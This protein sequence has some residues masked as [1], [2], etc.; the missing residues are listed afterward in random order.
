MKK[1]LLNFICCPICK[2]DAVDSW[3][4]SVTKES[5][6]EVRE[7]TVTCKK[8]RKIFV[9]EE[10]ILDLLVNPS[11]E[12]VNE[13]AGWAKLEKHVKNDDRLMLSLPNGIGEHKAVWQLQSEN[14]NYMW[15]KIDLKGDEKVLDLGAG[16]CWAT[17]FFAK[18]GC[19]T[20]GLDVLKTKYVGLLTSDVYIN[21]EG[22]YFERLIGNMNDIPIKKAVFDIVFMAATLHH[23]SDINRTIQQVYNSLK[24]GG[25]LIMINEPGLSIFG[26]KKLTCPEVENG[27][28]EHVYRLNEYSKVLRHNGFSYDLYPYVGS[29][30][31]IIQKLNGGLTRI[32]PKQL[33]PKR[34][35]KPLLIAQL[36]FW[37]GV[38]HVMARKR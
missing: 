1:Q 33:I 16:R 35:W 15:S 19:Y 28:N 3:D 18:A 8:C 13:Q 17:R 29:Y 31:K 21:N 5:K 2:S 10:G 7:G 24:P 20:V 38:V 11:N 23:S 36:L 22:V 14:F 34:M 4:L 37:G 30:A 27:I 25:R 6:E 9:I 12:I 26:S 32:F